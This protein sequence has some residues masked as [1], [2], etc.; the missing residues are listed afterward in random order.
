MI[1]NILKTIEKLFIRHYPG[2]SYCLYLIYTTCIPSLYPVYTLSV[3]SVPS[4]YPVLYPV[5]TQLVS[6]V[7]SLYP[8]YPVYIQRTQRT[9]FVPSVPSLNFFPTRTTTTRRRTTTRTTTTTIIRHWPALALQVKMASS[10]PG[11]QMSLKQFFTFL[12]LLQ[13]LFYGTLAETAV[14]DTFLNF[15]PTTTTTRR[16]TR[17]TRTTTTT[18]IRHWPALALHVK[19]VNYN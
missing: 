14:L 8:V 9:Q 12:H 1:A 7:P 15:F 5:C 4:L 13:L 11:G 2:Y 6:D 16:T 10:D 3:P 18:I 17:T 19:N